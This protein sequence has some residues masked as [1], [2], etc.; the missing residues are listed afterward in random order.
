[1]VAEDKIKQVIVMRTDLK[2]RKGKMIAQGAHA[3][4]KWLTD[5]LKSDTY[6]YGL[7]L[8]QEQDEW[9]NG[10]FTKI[11]VQVSSEQELLDT[12]QKA[13]DAGLHVKEIIDNGD[14]EFKGVKTLTCCAI[15]PDYSSK[16]DPITRKLPLL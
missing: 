8:T 10:S 3:A 12:I 2:M 14:T 13:K 1:M 16:I 6:E 4:I 15:G 7:R 5:K 11:C 9:V